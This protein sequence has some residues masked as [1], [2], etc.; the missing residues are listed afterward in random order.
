MH[1]ANAGRQRV[2]DTLEVEATESV[3]KVLANSLW[4]LS[5]LGH[6]P[7]PALLSRLEGLFANYLTRLLEGPADWQPPHYPQDVGNIFVSLVKLE[8]Q[9]APG[10]APVLQSV[11]LRSLPSFPESTL[12]MTLW[13]LSKVPGAP[14][15]EFAA[16]MYSHLEEGIAT[17]NPG[18][19]SHLLSIYS[20]SG[21]P[22]SDS[23]LAAIME[24]ID[25]KLSTYR[26]LDL[27]I[28]LHAL[29]SMDRKPPPALAKRLKEAL[30]THLGS[31]RG[32]EDQHLA[33]ALWALTRLLD[34]RLAV[35]GRLDWELLEGCDS[36]LV[37]L[38]QKQRIASSCLS[39]CVWSLARLDFNPSRKLLALSA[40]AMRRFLRHGD[41]KPQSLGQFMWALSSLRWYDPELQDMVGSLLEKQ[42]GA[43]PGGCGTGDGGGSNGGNHGLDDIRQYNQLLMSFATFGHHSPVLGR[44]VEAL[45]EHVEERWLASE[46][47]ESVNQ[48][49]TNCLWAMALLDMLDAPVTDRLIEVLGACQAGV[50]SLNRLLPQ[51]YHVPPHQQAQAKEAW[52]GNCLVTVTSEFQESIFRVLSQLVPDVKMEDMSEGGMFMIDMAFRDAAGKRVA[53][54]ADGPRHFTNS[55][56]VRTLRAYE[57]RND[58]LRAEG[59][60]VV[61]IPF[62]DW[63]LKFETEQEQLVYLRQLMADHGV[64]LP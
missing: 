12:V 34:F 26:D 40:T 6:C 59:Y 53:V 7:T 30:L 18:T 39:V 21:H 46:S 62:Y 58:M 13:A 22:P 44:L 57:L 16:A 37:R 14:T 33:M 42:L 9:F 36:A 61:N 52:R 15:P 19:L 5:R 54:E 3:A 41:V 38:L 51:L 63:H 1:I 10:T 25:S 4:G 17:L 29:A 23:F 20:S 43:S 60:I 2:A 56:P 47:P 50:P 28:V 35:D 11:L 8:H 24:A 32:L 45:A 27:V 55:V 49:V 48:A 64:T 31:R